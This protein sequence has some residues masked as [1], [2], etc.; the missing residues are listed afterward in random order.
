MIHSCIG[1]SRIV[2]EAPPGSLVVDLGATKVAAA[3]SSRT[4]TSALPV[5]PRATDEL[6]WVTA[7]IAED[8]TSAIDRIVVAAAPEMD[9][10]GVVRRWPNRPG[11]LGLS[12]G[13]ALA[14]DGVSVEILA[15]G[16][17]AALGEASEQGLARMLYLGLGTGVAT[18]WV[19]DG[20]PV[21]LREPIDLAHTTIADRSAVCV[22]G[23]RGCVQAWAS[24]R[25]MMDRIV[26]LGLGDLSWNDIARRW[27]GPALAQ[28][29]R[30][31]VE[32]LAAAS[33][34]GAEVFGCEIVVIGGRLVTLL[35]EL[36]AEVREVVV[37]GPDVR[38][39]RLG[40]DATLQGAAALA[41]TVHPSPR[42]QC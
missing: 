26:E 9:A 32:A 17:A 23:R 37:D 13:A 31:A 12:L 15:D 20:V 34:V 42:P 38:A 27:S 5:L 35:P 33:R 2:R 7:W 28:V 18:G 30:G 10:H 19:V 41:Q 16:A 11:W 14:W 24:G 21:P 8:L 25:G 36:V 1:G 22:C 4:R 6:A 39:G 40:G 29:R 3:V